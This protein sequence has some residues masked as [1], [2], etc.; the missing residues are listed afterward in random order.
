MKSQDIFILLKLV[1][2]ESQ[3]SSMDSDCYSVRNLSASLGVSKTEVS[4]SINR[5]IYANLAVRDR[6]HNFPKANRKGLL[7]FIIHGLKYVFPVKPAEICRG[8][9]T[10]FSAPVFAN[11]LATAGEILLV[12]PDPL[13]AEKGQ[14]ITPLFK[15][16][17]DAVRQDALLYELL[18]LADAIRL[19]NPREL[20]LAI[21]LLEAR[22][23]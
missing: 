12:W 18:A 3:A 14:S 13:G 7:E 16:V 23:I 17:P 15:T 9:A 5:S 21:Q 8:T 6:S 1:S 10:A 11:Q 19:G 2:L 22:M 4:A 20:K